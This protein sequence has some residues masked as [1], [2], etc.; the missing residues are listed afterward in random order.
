MTAATPDQRVEAYLAMLRD[1]RRLSPHTLK[2]ARRDLSA[3]LAYLEQRELPPDLHA[4]RGFLAEQ[5]RRGRSPASLHRY[6]SS[7]RGWFRF[8]VREGRMASNPADGV[9]AP[10]RERPLPKTLGVDQVQSLM[11]PQGDEPMRIRDL[12]MLELLYSSGLRLAELVGLDLDSL[13]DD[14]RQV[15]VLGKGSKERVVPVGAKAREVLGRWCRER[16]AV[17]GIGEN[18]LF[19]GHNGK[20]ITPRTVQTR[21]AAWAKRAGLDVGL[22]PHRLRHSFASHLLQSSGDLRAVQELLGHANIGTTQVYTHLDFSFLSGVYDAAH[23][24]A[25]RKRDD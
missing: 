2:A 24:R 23:P 11:E 10:K 19:V 7:L 18:A 1:E 6:L 21:L 17:A 25:R 13:S 4:V 3:F 8:E 5:N 22:H 16:A 12:A 9:K 15:R 14:A 20:R